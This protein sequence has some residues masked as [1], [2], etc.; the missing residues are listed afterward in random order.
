MRQ[1]C[2]EA[3]Q[4]Q[5]QISVKTEVQEAELTGQSPNPVSIDLPIDREYTASVRQTYKM[6]SQ[7]DD[8]V[9]DAVPIL[10]RIEEESQ[11]SRSAGASC[12]CMHGT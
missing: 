2:C 11:V 8:E 5:G 3:N 12:A 6:G 1:R 10:T 4:S 9:P 7:S